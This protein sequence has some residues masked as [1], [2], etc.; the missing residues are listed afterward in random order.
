MRIGSGFV[1][2][3]LS[4]LLHTAVLL[5]AITVWSEP[6][7]RPPQGSPTG[8]LAWERPAAAPGSP[9]V[10]SGEEVAHTATSETFHCPLL[11]MEASEVPSWLASATVA[12]LPPPL[13]Q[14]ART[15]CTGWMES[16]CPKS[17]SSLASLM[18][19][20][21]TGGD[22]QGAAAQEGNQ[23]APAGGGMVG[24]DPPEAT[25]GDGSP[26][27]GE[28]LGV[29]DGLPRALPGNVPPAYPETARRMGWEG[30]VLL[31]L[32]ILSDGRVARVEVARSSGH[33]VLD[34]E[35]VR[36]VSRWRFA[37]Q[38]QGVVPANAQRLLP[39]RF[40]LQDR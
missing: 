4:V 28:P 30:E 13:A 23:A 12:A 29:P 32:Q 31:R 35:A 15:L 14:E 7:T 40:S 17:L 18:R 26:G 10:L 39:V 20:R 38:A 19:G 22:A 21:G 33:K 27:G 37:P 36:A 25:A 6:A 3:G 34:Q 8:E 2:F 16:V 1:S 5:A 24:G 11:D 9:E